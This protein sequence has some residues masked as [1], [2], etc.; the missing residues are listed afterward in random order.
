MGKFTKALFIGINYT[1]LP[2]NHLENCI[3][4]AVNMQEMIRR[5]SQY[6]ECRVLIDTTETRPELLPTK[7]NI[8]RDIKW[9]LDVPSG[10]NIF[11]HYSGHGGSV[12]DKTNKESDGKNETLCNLDFLTVGEIID[13]ELNVMIVKHVVE[14]N[15]HLTCITDSCHSGS[16]MDERFSMVQKSDTVV[17]D[18]ASVTNS[19][20]SPSL[21]P[22]LAPSLTSVQSNQ[23][24]SQ[25]PPQY[26]PQFGQ[27]GSPQQH[28]YSSQ[29]N[30]QFGKLNQQP[31]QFGPP[32]FNHQFNPQHSSQFNPHHSSQFNPQHSNQ[33]IQVLYQGKWYNKQDFD[34]KFIKPLVKDYKIIQRYNKYKHDMNFVNNYDRIRI[35]EN[36]KV[37]VLI[38]DMKSIREDIDD[39]YIQHMLKYNEIATPVPEQ[40]RYVNKREVLI[41]NLE[42]TNQ[43]NYELQREITRNYERNMQK[44]FPQIQQLPFSPF[45]QNQAFSPFLEIPQNYANETKEFE[46]IE[47]KNNRKVEVRSVVWSS[48]E[49]KNMPKYEGTGSIL[50]ISGCSDHQTSADGYNGRENGALTG[51]ILSILNNLFDSEGKPT[52]ISVGELLYKIRQNLKLN[53]F[54]QVPQI[55]SNDALDPNTIINI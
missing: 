54:E 42:L 45:S 49:D 21:A 33:K 15:I 34:N 12:R 11:I 40:V 6:D 1:S 14:N 7:Q 2:D 47:Y 8:F 28:S 24:Y 35:K 26:L 3:N 19:T 29:F 18:A 53:R 46:D 48:R 43:I 9:I 5:R 16:N 52:Y 22:S 41:S 27:F 38:N 39:P 13:D 31:G 10:S 4:D 36:N 44:Y 50:K 32:Q 30:P 20:S 17:N 25:Y 37:K 23:F 55:C 51:C